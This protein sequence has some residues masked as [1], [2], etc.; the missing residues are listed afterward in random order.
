M[1]KFYAKKILL[2]AM[3]LGMAYMPAKAQDYTTPSFERQ[4]M[5]LPKWGIK[6]NL[7]YDLTATINLGVEFRTGDK[8]SFELPVSWNP[9]TFSEG[10]KWKHFLVQPEF[11]W[12]TRETFSGHFFGLH[13]HY[14]VY[15]TILPNPPFTQ[16]MRDHRFEGWLA[17]AGVS[18]GYRWNFNH[19]WAMEA[20]LGVGYAYMNYEKLPSD[21][22]AEPIASLQ[23]HY[24]GPTKVGLNLIYGIGGRAGAKPLREARPSRVH[25][26]PAVRPVPPTGTPTQ[27]MVIVSEPRIMA[28]FIAPE[29]EFTG[30][31]FEQGTSFLNFAQ[32]SSALQLDFGGNAAELERIHETMA[33]LLGDPRTTITGITITGFASPEDTYTRNQ[34]LSVN[35]ARV[36]ANHLTAIYGLPADLIAVR[37]GGEDWET[38]DVLVERSFMPERFMALEII[39]G[40]QNPDERLRRLTTLAGGRVYDQIR[41]LYPRLRRLDYH[42]EYT[43]GVLSHEDMVQ[44][45]RTRPGNLTMNELFVLANQYEPGS[46]EFCEVIQTAAHLFPDVDVVNINAA[47]GAL[48]RGDTNMAVRF[49]SRVSEHGPA[50]WNNMGVL[51]WLHGDLDK[52]IEFFGRGGVQGAGNLAEIERR[53]RPAGAM[54]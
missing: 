35:R 40:T 12:W 51:A 32:G 45:F 11:R 44:T 17:G 49:L 15:N 37:G 39:R 24:F 19:R 36:L 33:H 50:Y 28:T 16:Y 1:K 25:N 53:S 34:T 54:Q 5:M 27:Q 21:V 10:V 22:C 6:T 31:T 38:I 14:A 7:L 42:I 30:A 4:M 43:A 9:F 29:A 47:A 23:K 8:T 3:L 52:A 48:E 20:T 41:A 18:Y 46:E 26:R 13:G 2:S